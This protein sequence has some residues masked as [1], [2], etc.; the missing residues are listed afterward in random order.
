MIRHTTNHKFYKSHKKTNTFKTIYY[1]K[2]KGGIIH[3]I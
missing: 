3:A 2:I 1:V